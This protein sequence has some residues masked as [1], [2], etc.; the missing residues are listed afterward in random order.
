MARAA[1]ARPYCRPRPHAARAGPLVAAASASPGKVMVINES[2]GSAAE[3]GAFMFKLGKVGA[4]V[5]KATYGGGIGPYFFTPRL[6]DG[7]RVQ[8]PNRAAY[9][10][11][12]TTWGIEN[13]G[14][15]PDY[16]VEI[17]PRDV[18]AGRDPRLEKAVEV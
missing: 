13:V 16:D 6:A 7:G 11:D 12:G 15:Q 3:T 5:G 18:M 17:T 14:V 10:P 2:N 8:L 9:N 4:I 1:G